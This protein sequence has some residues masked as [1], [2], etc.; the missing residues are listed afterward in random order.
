MSCW[1]CLDFVT[2]IVAFEMGEVGIREKL[3]NRYNIDP[4]IRYSIIE[5]LRNLRWAL[6]REANK[7]NKKKI[8]EKIELHEKYLSILRDI[9][10]MKKI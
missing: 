8:I 7:S 5:H 2:Q 3:L 6:S 1:F 4:F 9:R 10:Y